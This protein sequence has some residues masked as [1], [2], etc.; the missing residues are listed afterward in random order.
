MQLGPVEVPSDIYH[1]IVVVAGTGA[2]NMLDA[3][4]VAQICQKMD[5]FHVGEWITADLG[6]YAALILFGRV[7]TEERAV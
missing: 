4:G 6:R 1:A 3:H 7:S 2:I 5:L